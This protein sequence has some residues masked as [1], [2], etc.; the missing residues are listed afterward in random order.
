MGIDNNPLMNMLNQ[1]EE[2][3][4]DRQEIIKAP[5]GW[6]GGKLKSLEHILPLLPIH[7]SYIEPFGGSG[8]VLL[9]RKPSALEVFNDRYSG[10][11]DFYRCMRDEQQ[12]R[13]LDKYLET[14]L[15]SREDWVECFNTWER[16]N[17]PVERAAKW[18]YMVKY[19]FGGKGKAFGRSTF[20]S[21]GASGKLFRARNLFWPVHNRLK[22]VLMENQDWRLILKDFD[23]DNAVFYLDPPYLTA[24]RGTYAHEMSHNEHELMLDTVFNMQAFVAVSSYPNKLYDG[25][26]WSHVH[27]WE[28]FCSM[29]GASYTEENNFKDFEHLMK[30]EKAKEV[31][32]IKEAK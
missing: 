1:L 25:Y 14:F 22:N 9:N 28:V 11:V 12:C 13:A 21:N 18:L 24:H 32:Y 8:S 15:H 30:R 19:S 31:L 3:T 17:D 5:F 27:E 23:K 26:P 20:D 6:P 7:D 10:V 29:K 16:C 4:F 2:P